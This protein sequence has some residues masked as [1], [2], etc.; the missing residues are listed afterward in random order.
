MIEDFAP[1]FMHL[2][3]KK[4]KKMKRMEKCGKYSFCFKFGT[5]L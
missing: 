2:K 3:E 1:L 5:K 4:Y